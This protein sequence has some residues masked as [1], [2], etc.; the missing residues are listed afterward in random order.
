MLKYTGCNLIHTNKLPQHLSSSIPN[1]NSIPE[2]EKN[3]N[4]VFNF[5]FLFFIFSVQ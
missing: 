2:K 4:Q 3:D 5:E 1:V